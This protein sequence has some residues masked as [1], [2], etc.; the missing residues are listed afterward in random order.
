MFT[1]MAEFEEPKRLRK[2][3]N[4]LWLFPQIR[5][6][7][8]NPKIDKILNFYKVDQTN[9]T[10]GY[11]FTFSYIT[12]SELELTFDAAHLLHP[13]FQSQLTLLVPLPHRN[14]QMLESQ[15][16][17]WTSHDRFQRNDLYR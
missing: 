9:D 1:G 10:I 12:G 11:I 2:E 16:R 14:H 7:I 8:T 4:K 5:I 15:S 3:H 17:R 13:L 6:I